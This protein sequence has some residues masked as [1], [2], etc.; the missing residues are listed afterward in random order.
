MIAKNN[1]AE[2]VD[3]GALRVDHSQRQGTRGGGDDGDDD[4]RFSHPLTLDVKNKFYEQWQQ[5]K[6][7]R[8]D[9]LEGECL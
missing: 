1:C 2:D 8:K 4:A 5:L 7:E 6:R 3:E 9:R